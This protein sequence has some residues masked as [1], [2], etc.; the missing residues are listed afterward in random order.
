V[1]VKRR[2]GEAEKRHQYV[3]AVLE[4]ARIE[5]YAGSVHVLKSDLPPFSKGRVRPPAQGVALEAVH[6]LDMT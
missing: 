4:Q 3:V 5:N 2:P 1:F 6:G